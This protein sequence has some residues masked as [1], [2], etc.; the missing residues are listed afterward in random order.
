MSITVKVKYTTDELLDILTRN[1]PEFKRIDKSRIT[2]GDLQLFAEQLHTLALVDN[3]TGA[4]L[5]WLTRKL[6]LRRINEILEEGGPDMPPETGECT[7][8]EWATIDW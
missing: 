2:M 6:V 7:P 3:R 1:V 8:N 4:P 5:G